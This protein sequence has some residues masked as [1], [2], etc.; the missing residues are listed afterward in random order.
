MHYTISDTLLKS[1]ANE[2][3]NCF[4]FKINQSSSTG[5]YPGSLKLAIVVQI[6]K[7]NDKLEIRIYHSIS[8]LPVSS[9]IFKDV[10]HTQ[11]LE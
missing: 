8:I 1:N 9:K 11:L 2:V 10:M 5:T 7:K 4:T 6:F 3:S